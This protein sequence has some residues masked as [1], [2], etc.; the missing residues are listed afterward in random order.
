MKKFALTPLPRD[1]TSGAYQVSETFLDVGNRMGTR[2][3]FTALL[4]PHSSTTKLEESNSDLP[5]FDLIPD[6]D[7]RIFGTL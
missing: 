4:C 5:P 3:Y 6:P 1:P 7:K 2:A